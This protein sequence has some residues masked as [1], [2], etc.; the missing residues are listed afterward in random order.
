[1]APGK[2][3]TLFIIN[4][5]LEKK[6]GENLSSLI[7]EHLD[8]EKFEYQMLHSEY[9]GHT[10]VLT[11]E[12]AGKYGLIVAGGGDGT[13]NQVAS[14]L[15]H[16]K[17]LLGIL[18]LGSGKGL[19]RALGIPQDIRKAVQVLN[20]CN[21]SSIDTGLVGTHRF[22]NIAGIGFAAEVAAAY[23][24]SRTRGFFPYAK[25][26][27]KKLPGY[28]PV[29]VEVKNEKRIVSGSFFDIS[30][31]NSTQWG[32]GAHISPT[33]KPDDGLLEICILRK[34]PKLLVPGLLLRLYTKT[35]HRSRY[36]DI[37]PVKNAEISGQESF[38]GHVDGEPVD[39]TAPFHI[40]VEPGSLRV[41]TGLSTH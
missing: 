3:K 1:M 21:I 37:I 20:K 4:P 11:R 27:I 35:I 17:T 29:F 41:L 10:S 12:N 8:S 22:V 32:Y 6:R 26:I 23:E 15:V 9:P 25:N 38:K 28:S 31:A 39:L 7:S 16:S 34:F 13:V 2:L 18:P 24:G 30:F 19:S 5:I 14:G 33:S 40:S 36:M